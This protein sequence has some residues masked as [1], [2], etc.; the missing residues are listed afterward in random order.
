MKTAPLL[1]GAAILFWGLEVR[2]LVPAAF[3]AVAV[4]ASRWIKHRWDF[5]EA[6][7]KRVSAFCT[8]ALISIAIYRLLTGWFNHPAWMIFKWLPVVLLPLFLAQIYSTAEHINL[9]VLFLFGKKLNPVDQRKPRYIDLSY[10][11]LASCIFAAGF[12][13][14]RDGLFY[15]GM[16]CLAGWTLWSYRARR[17]PLAVW[18]V[19]LL[20]AAGAG[21]LGQM[22]LSRL[23]TVVEQKTANWY[24]KSIDAPFRKYTQIGE[25]HD[26]KLSSRIVFRARTDGIDERSLLLREAT[27]DTFRSNLSIWSTSR[28]YFNR[29]KNTTNSA[30]WRLATGTGDTRTCTIAQNFERNDALLKLPNGVFQ[31]DNLKVYRVEK[32]DFGAVKVQGDGLVTYHTRY[33]HGSPLI[34]PPGAHD[35]KIS[36]RETKVIKRIAD[37]L[38]LQSLP[39]AEIL[40]KVKTYFSTQFTYSL[41]QKSKLKNSTP[42]VNFLSNTRS[43][44]CEFFATATVLLLRQAGVPARY[45]K[46]YAVDPSDAMDGWSLVRSRYAHAWAVAY[47]N[48]IWINLDTTPGTWLEIERQQEP[49]WQKYW[50]GIMDIV[51]G[52]MFRFAQWRQKIQTKGHLKYFPLLLLPL[53]LWAGWRIFSIFLKRRKT[54]K[55]IV[56]ESRKPRV[57]AGSDSAFYRIEQRL[58]SLGLTRHP[59]ETFSAWLNRIERTAGPTISLDIP[60]KSLA[61]HNRY[62]FDPLGLSASEKSRLTSM[63]SAWLAENHLKSGTNNN[64]DV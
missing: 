42:I 47:V 18:I 57:P 26:G 25:I 33:G 1:I 9:R 56:S 21:Y 27:Y 4:E 39:P 52:A 29:L 36:K 19:L 53:F 43:G 51:S 38:D 35:L 22:G 50:Q 13:N 45:A 61:L 5:K 6:D 23:Q 7:F 24:N 31:V 28:R 20:V 44:H 59:W 37:Q 10:I 17:S 15:I 3:M 32:N 12:A 34:S 62:R 30:S 48:G 58:N 14:T 8:L 41:K 46:G 40:K 64:P 11:Y 49:Y 55:T 2:Q 63:I 60:R 54:Q 16:L